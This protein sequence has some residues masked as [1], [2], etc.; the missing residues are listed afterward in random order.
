[1][2]YRDVLELTPMQ[3]VALCT[4][5]SDP[6][7]RIGLDTLNELKTGIRALYGQR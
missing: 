3:V 6:P 7:E 4:E 1:M 2:S 5:K